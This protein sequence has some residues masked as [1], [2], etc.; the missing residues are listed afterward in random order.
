MVESSSKTV[1]NPNTKNNK[2]NK[3]TKNSN[4]NVSNRLNMV[5][6]KI[7]FLSLMMEIPFSL[8]SAVILI[9]GNTGSVARILQDIFVT[10]DTTTNI[11]FLSYM[12]E[13][14]KDSFDKFLIKY[15]QLITNLKCFNCLLFENDYSDN[16][17]KA[18][19]AGTRMR[20][21]TETNNGES[22][23]TKTK[24]KIGAKSVI[25]IEHA[26]H[27]AVSR[28]ETNDFSVL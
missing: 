12:H 24:T 17:E 23:F 21:K 27:S 14:N 20:Q 3:S 6:R 25:E 26:Q 16:N 18:P 11:V 2:N 8:V 5:L 13:Y 7:L 28:E 4:N 9:G 1:S 10:I 22:E 19:N 15:N